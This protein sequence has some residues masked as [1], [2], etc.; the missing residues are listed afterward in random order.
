MIAAK[1][2]GQLRL[3]EGHRLDRH[4]QAAPGAGVAGTT[5]HGDV[6]LKEYGAEGL[7]TVDMARGPGVWQSKLAIK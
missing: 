1:T 6:V 2:G 7:H 5:S 3:E 4:G